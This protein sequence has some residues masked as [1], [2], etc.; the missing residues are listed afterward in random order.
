MAAKIIGGNGFEP[1]FLDAP[2]PAPELTDV[3]GQDKELPFSF[4][5]KCYLATHVSIEFAHLVP[6]KH[7]DRVPCEVELGP[8]NWLRLSVLDGDL[9]CRTCHCRPDRTR[10]KHRYLSEDEDEHHCETS[11]HGSLTT[12]RLPKD[13]PDPHSSLSRSVPRPHLSICPNPLVHQMHVSE[14]LARAGCYASRR[15]R[16]SRRRQ[17]PEAKISNRC[18][19]SQHSVPRAHGSNP[20]NLFVDKHPS[21]D[22]LS[23]RRSLRAFA[24]RV[25]TPPTPR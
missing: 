1:R 4:S 22:G 19:A 15:C 20:R 14:Q 6:R 7:R 11:L 5:T 3:R 9:N 25:N 10:R 13:T 23:S 24:S 12:F 21:H 8:L 17:L 18:E 2:T 16:L